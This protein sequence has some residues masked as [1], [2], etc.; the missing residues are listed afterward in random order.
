M[1]NHDEHKEHKHEREHVTAETLSVKLEGSEKARSWIIRGVVIFLVLVF[2]GGLALGANDLLTR[3]G[4]QPPEQELD[5]TITDPPEGEEA[6][7]AY[8]Q[9]AID[10]ALAEKPK[11]AYDTTFE[12]AKDN[13]YLDDIAFAF[14]D[15]GSADTALNEAWLKNAVRLVAL[16]A[17]EH[18]YDSYPSGE[19]QYGEDFTQTLW[20]MPFDPAQLDDA[21]CTFVYYRCTACGKGEDEWKAQCPECKAKGTEE[22]PIMV[23]DYRGNYALTLYFTDDSPL[24]DEVFRTRAP[25][26]II[27]MLEEPLASA[28]ALD[29]IDYTFRNARIEAAIN[30]TTGKLQ[31]LKFK[32][33]VDAKL[34]LAL[35][36]QFS[37][38]G[39]AALS[40]TVAQSE[41]FRF[42]WPA[43]VLSSHERV[44]DP[45]EN[46]QLTVRIDA[47]DGQE[48]PHTWATTDLDVCSVDQEGY[49]KAGKQPGEAI[50]SVNFVL[51]GVTYTDECMIHVKVPVEKAQLNHRSLK[52]ALGEVKQLIATVTPR[53]ASYKGVTWNSENP[54]IASVD[55]NG[56]VTALAPGQTAVYALSVDGYY[57]ATCIVTVTGG[58]G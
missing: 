45:K 58:E 23:K 16:G 46:S 12:Y 21:K 39:S 22:K 43:A 9:A 20:N 6:I 27:G 13:D 15:A 49:L 26:E 53:N 48:T 30:R 44:M 5:A 34:G 51:D 41:N 3:E 36:P 56:N 17:A 25:E 10:M 32:R 40:I 1:S 28:A 35:E 31:T 8:M 4:Q 2:F 57:R 7:Y 33:D 38:L 14:S 18:L 47:P 42:T 55:A 52:L 19:T 29:S 11:F 37:G 24:I 54:D 50:V